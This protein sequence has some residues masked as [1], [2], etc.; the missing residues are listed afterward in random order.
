MDTS[1]AKKR[2]FINRI[3][4]IL[5]NMYMGDLMKRLSFITNRKLMKNIFQ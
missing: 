3:Y 4:I 1:L 2:Y 5:N